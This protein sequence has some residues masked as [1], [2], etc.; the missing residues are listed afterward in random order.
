MPLFHLQPFLLLLE[1]TNFAAPQR[2]LSASSK[3]ASRPS[4]KGQWRESSY[5]GSSLNLGSWL[6]TGRIPPNGSDSNNSWDQAEK[7]DLFVLLLL[8]ADWWNLEKRLLVSWPS[9][10]SWRWISTKSVTRRPSRTD[11]GRTNSNKYGSFF[12]F[13]SP[14]R[15]FSWSR[16]FRFLQWRW[17]CS[18]TD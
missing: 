13:H 15:F 10:S 8:P 17:I 16:K 1:C 18:S 5:S 11:W 9:M 14:F 6:K 12:S 2:K 4:K 7:G 3:C